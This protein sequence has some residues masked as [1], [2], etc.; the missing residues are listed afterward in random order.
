MATP[1]VKL[2]GQTLKVWPYFGPEAAL[3]ADAF[4]SG[5]TG[6]TPLSVTVLDRRRSVTTWRDVLQMTIQAI[7]ENSPDM[8]DDIVIKFPKLLS[9][10]PEKLRTPREVSDNALYFESNQ[11]ANSTVRYCQQVTES[12]GY[13]LSDWSVETRL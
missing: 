3:S 7:R 6:R 10:T 13:S 2:S 1:S 9:R 5:Y 11:S 4:M 8:F 12:A